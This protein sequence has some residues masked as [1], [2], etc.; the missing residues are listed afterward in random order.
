MLKYISLLFSIFTIAFT[1]SSFT[2]FGCTDI[3]KSSCVPNLQPFLHNGQVN[4]VIL[5]PGESSS[6]VLSF[7]SGNTYRLATCA[8][9]NAAEVY[10]EVS[11]PNSDKILYSSKDKQNSSWDFKVENSRKLVVNV[12]APKNLTGETCVGLSVGFLQ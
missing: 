9:G 11:S 3:I 12:V 10:F 5:N 1:T 2:P 6:T 4:S 8:N 7:Y